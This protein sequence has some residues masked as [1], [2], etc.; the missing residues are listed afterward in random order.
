MSEGTKQNL[1][2]IANTLLLVV[3][4]IV[5]S[6][7]VRWMNGMESRLDGVVDS[8][9]GIRLEIQALR[10][11]REYEKGRMAGIKEALEAAERVR[12]EPK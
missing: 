5:G 9:S 4:A 7:I 2:S 1:W 12:G 6:F 11:E 10:S 8:V 3:V